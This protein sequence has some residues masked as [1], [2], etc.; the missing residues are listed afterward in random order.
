MCVIY[1]ININ[2]QKILAKNRDRYYKPEITIY[3]EIIN[4]I[5]VVYIKDENH[6]WIEGMN[7]LGTG[8]VNS[9]LSSEK[10]HLDNKSNFFK[11]YKFKCNIIYNAITEPKKNNFFKEILKNKNELYILEGHSLIAFNDIIYHLENNKKNNYYLEPFSNNKKFQVYT[12]H[13]IHLKKNGYKEGIKAVS[14]FLRRESTKKELKNVLKKD[15]I[16]CNDNKLYNE[17]SSIFNKNYINIDPRF[18]SYRDKKVILNK[19]NADENTNIISTTAQI[20]MN[21]SNKEFVYFKDKN[22]SENVTYINKLPQ[23]YLPKIR[24]IIKETEKN[25]EPVK[26]FNNKYL[27][28]IYKRFKY[29]ENDDK[30]EDDFNS[31]NKTN[32]NRKIQKNK[33]RKINKL[34]QK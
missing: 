21:I 2:G 15:N 31:K 3:H 20:F 4:G 25:M 23:N 10:K 29:D 30:Y 12:N 1:Y 32:K 7:E 33:T 27:N 6:G 28:K 8:I 26:M 34:Y 18:H 22:N 9:T 5:E 11:K 14:S 24:V 17:L 16:V 13:G 19:T